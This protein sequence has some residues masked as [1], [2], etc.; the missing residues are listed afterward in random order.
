M[1][2]VQGMLNEWS[3]MTNQCIAKGYDTH[4]IVKN[5]LEITHMEITYIN[6]YVL[7]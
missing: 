7:I 5:I 4:M 6:I 1:T 2:V 3:V